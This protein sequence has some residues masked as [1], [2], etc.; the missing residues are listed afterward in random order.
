MSPADYT[1][2]HRRDTLISAEENR[3]MFDSIS[4]RYDLMNLVLS[5]GLDRYWRR[6]AVKTLLP[7]PD[8]LIFDI[9]SGTGD[10]ALEILRQ[11]PD[12]RVVGIDQ[13]KAMLD[14]AERKAALRGLQNAIRFEPGDA[15]ALQYPDAAFDGIIS[16]F[17]IRNVEDRAKAFAEMYRVLKPGRQAV[18]L[19]LSKPDCVLLRHG[20]KFYNR[21]LVPFVG[22]IL[23]RG[24]A[25][26]YLIDSIEDFPDS[27]VMMGIMRKEGFQKV[28]RLPLTG[29]IVT[30]F[31]GKR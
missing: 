23:S 16:A 4:R 19:E 22:H 3:K 13:A 1:H 18:A 28:R 6:K 24:N 26:K 8:D 15:V 17:C 5:L 12:A 2:R 11:Q 30:I 20:H 27:E 21:V 10:I 14:I 9:G 29:G 25:Y 7:Q 31:V